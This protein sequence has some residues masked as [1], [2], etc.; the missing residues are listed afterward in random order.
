MT[1]GKD[2]CTPLIYS[3]VWENILS[4]AA[5][6]MWRDDLSRGREA[7]SSPSPLSGGFTCAFF[8]VLN[9]TRHT[10]RARQLSSSR[11][12]SL[13]KKAQSP[14]CSSGSKMVQLVPAVLLSYFERSERASKR[15]SDPSKIS[16]L[17]GNFVRIYKT[18]VERVEMFA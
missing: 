11:S 2:V 14:L 5:R 3:S 6:Q 15:W 10:C 1:S 9:W 4:L 17:R 16:F 13:L 12:V 18:R 8:N 7:R